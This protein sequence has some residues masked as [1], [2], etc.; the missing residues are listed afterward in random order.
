MMRIGTARRAWLGVAVLLG[1]LGSA[2]RARAVVSVY[3]GSATGVPGGTAT[4]Q[5]VLT[6]TGEQV[7]G[8]Q[9][10]ITFDSLTP[11]ASC[12][13]NPL[14]FPTWSLQPPGCTP[15]ANCTHAN[16]VLLMQQLGTTIPNGSTLYTC[17]VSVAS[18]ADVISYPLTCSNASAADV[19]HNTLQVQCSDGQIQVVPILVSA[20]PKDSRTLTVT[21]PAS[22]S[23]AFAGFPK[24]GTIV[25]I[26]I[27]ANLSIRYTLGS[28]NRTLTLSSPLPLD[29]A[30]GTEIIVVASASA[31][32]GGGGGGGCQITLL[33]QRRAG[34]LLLL[35][36]AVLLWSRRRR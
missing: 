18:D 20:A 16:F 14:L 33:H 1:L 5:V 25:Q 8:V 27:T 23:P 28:D 6:T 36:A 10:T 30:D 12:A 13:I 7:G 34:W 26:G 21:S 4:F 35:P 3:V 9:N 32:K 19:N 24:T 11:I 22:T 15:L 29:V 17:T 31:P 2:P